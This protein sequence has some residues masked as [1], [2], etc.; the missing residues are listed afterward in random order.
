MAFRLCPL[1]TQG[2]IEALELRG[3]DEL[4]QTYLPKM[5]AGEWTGTMN[6]TEP[7]AGSDLAAGAHAAPCQRRAI[8]TSS[9]GRRSSSPTASTISRSNIMHLVLARTPDAP[10]GVKGISLFV[11]PKFLVNAD[12]SLGERNDAQLRL[13]RAQA[14]HPREP[15]RGDG[16][17]RRGRRVGY[18]VGEENRGLEYMFI[19]MNPARFCVGLEGVAIAERALPARARLRAGARAGRGPRRRAAKTVPIIQHPDVRR[20]LMTMKSQT[21]AM[22]ALAYVTAAA[23]DF[24][25]THPDE[26]TRKQHQ[27]FVDLMIPIVKGWSHRDGHRDRLARR[28]GARRHGLHRGD[29][30]RAAPARRAHHHDLRRHHRHPGERPRRPQDRARRRRHGEGM[31]GRAEV[32][33]RRAGALEQSRHSER[34]ARS[35]PPARRRSATASNSSS[36]TQASASRAFA[37]AVPF[38]KLAGIVAGGW[39]MAR[40]ALAAEKN[41][42]KDKSFYEAKIATARFY[43]DHVLVQAPGLRDTVV[44]GSA[45]VMALSEDQFLAA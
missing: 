39:Q 4:K 20:M 15:D 40:A 5:V 35:S 26:R 34:C 28:P 1:L 32:I 10:E 33:R 14:R 31:A 6:L 29:R 16:V 19:M 43:G 24:A 25:R 9:P 23:L 37:G 3:S 36:P 22:R 21:E 30:R 38:L 13:A 7:Q 11:V 8:T 45:G 27:A 41:L 17:R 42:S 44:K 2:A 18:L 12:G